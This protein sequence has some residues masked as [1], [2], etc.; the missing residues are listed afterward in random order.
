MEADPTHGA[1]A[2]RAEYNGL[3]QGLH[4][5]ALDP[6]GDMSR[7]EVVQVLC[8]LIDLLAPEAEDPAD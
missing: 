3:L 7:G 5:G 6:Y 1:N 4:L 8:N 2:A